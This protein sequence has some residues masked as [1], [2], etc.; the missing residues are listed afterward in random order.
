MWVA[1]NW[2][3]FSKAKRLM[4]ES[5]KPRA[6]WISLI[7]LTADTISRAV[8]RSMVSTICSC[9]ISTSSRLN[10]LHREM[11]SSKAIQSVGSKYAICFL[12]SSVIKST[13]VGSLICREDRETASRPRHLGLKAFSL[14]TTASANRRAKSVTSGEEPRN[15]AIAVPTRA[16]VSAS[17]FSNRL[18]RDTSS[19]WNRSSC[20]RCCTS[21]GFVTVPSCFSMPSRVGVSVLGRPSKCCSTSWADWMDLMTIRLFRLST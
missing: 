18:S 20:R 15:L 5:R 16:R 8:N 6:S 12:A 13:S 9:S 3:R 19:L 14:D 17:I 2:W 4:R 21:A 10:I 7:T 1:S 11:A